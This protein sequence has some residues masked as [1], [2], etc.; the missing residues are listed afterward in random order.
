M[1]RFIL[2]FL[3]VFISAVN[4]KAQKDEQKLANLTVRIEGKISSTGKLQLKLY[5]SESEWLEKG[6]RTLYIDLANDDNRTFHIEGLPAGT[7]A[8]AVIHDKNNNGELDMGMM[9]P[10]EKYGFSNNA[11]NMFGPAPYSD[12]SLELE[13]DTTIT[14]KL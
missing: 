1:N 10:T 11:K 6:I 7:Y 3:V 8:V 2:V 9:G 4:L 12:A 13:N 14:I 5:D